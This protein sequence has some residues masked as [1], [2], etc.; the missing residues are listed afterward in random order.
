MRRPIP[1]ITVGSMKTSKPVVAGLIS[2]LSGTFTLWYRASELIRVGSSPFGIVLG[3]VAIAGGICAI[4]RK[5]WG[6]ALVGAVC[7]IVP[8]HPWGFLIWTPVLGIVA[9]L[10]VVLSRSEFGGH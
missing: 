9:V 4:K 7:A 2:I 5:F 6:L 3:L 1:V 10:L 8:P